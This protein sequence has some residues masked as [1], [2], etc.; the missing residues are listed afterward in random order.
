MFGT[1]FRSEVSSLPDAPEFLRQDL[2][3]NKV[4]SAID[5]QQSHAGVS[6]R[7]SKLAQ[8]AVIL[9]QVAVKY[10]DCLVT[11]LT[12]FCDRPGDVAESPVK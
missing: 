7:G 6:E 12:Y 10:L 5:C 4:P 1:E 3:K 9:D 11:G 2:W 8:L